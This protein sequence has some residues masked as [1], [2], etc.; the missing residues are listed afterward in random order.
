MFRHYTII[1]VTSVCRYLILNINCIN[2]FLIFIIM[3]STMIY[4][5]VEAV[6]NS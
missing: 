2:F 1:T 5:N 3:E 4:Q 6:A